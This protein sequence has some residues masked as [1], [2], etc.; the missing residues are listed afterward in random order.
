MII[1]KKITNHIVSFLALTLLVVSGCSNSTISFSASTELGEQGSAIRMV[2]ISQYAAK[3]SK[4]KLLPLS[5]F[6]ALPPAEKYTYFKVSP[7]R[8]VFS[9]KFSNIQDMPVDFRK[10]TKG[11]SFWAQNQIRMIKRDCILLTAYDYEEKITDIVERIEVEES[12]KQA[13]DLLVEA[14]VSTLENEYGDDYD[15]ADF[16][17]YLRELLPPLSQRI[18]QIYWE[19]K[20]VD[21]Q[22]N[23][24]IVDQFNSLDYR[25]RKE[26]S[27]Y[28]ISLE[29]FWLKHG[30]QR[31]KKVAW[32]FLDSKLRELIKT[33][34]EGVTPFTASVFKGKDSQIK[35]LFK[36]LQEIQKSFGSVEE[37]MNQLEIPLIAGAFSGV[38]VPFTF[39]G[40]N[41]QFAASEPSFNFLFKTK[42]P[43]KVIQTNGVRDLNGT[44][45]W[46]FK[47]EDVM[48][49]GYRMWAKTLQ[50]NQN[51]IKRLHLRGFPGS[52]I[53]VERFYAIMTNRKGELNKGLTV[54]LATAVENESL[55]PIRNKANGGDDL[56]QKLLKFLMR[57]RNKIQPKENMKETVKPSTSTNREITKDRFQSDG[58][59]LD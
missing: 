26:I 1:G 53:N 29:P 21:T 59:E 32:S 40:N 2:S 27:N 10:K 48:F 17:N 45:V 3:S 38:N 51:A 6:I 44:L 34:K 52:I 41:L 33:K 9:G 22:G 46:R 55:D 43:G 8:I 58:P 37:F 15:F 57:Y 36:F 28:G 13:V 23:A 24:R 12:L 50:V 47:G 49:T 39:N 20:R 35:L 5:N 54:L 7:E 56:A 16:A 42:V 11:I 19:S 14:M 31:N 30:R 4:T 18:Y 25:I